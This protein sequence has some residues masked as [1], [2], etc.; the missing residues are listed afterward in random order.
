MKNSPHRQ[1]HQRAKALR[2]ACQIDLNPPKESSNNAPELN[3]QGDQKVPLKP[4]DMKKAKDI[5][6]I[7]KTHLEH[8]RYE[9]GPHAHRRTTPG[10]VEGEGPHIRD[11][12]Q[13]IQTNNLSTNLEKSSNLARKII[14]LHNEPYKKAA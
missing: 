6:N 1:K 11:Q 2:T 12:T 8:A 5:L 14:K 9:K 3:P 13:K 10:Q 7:Y 4:L